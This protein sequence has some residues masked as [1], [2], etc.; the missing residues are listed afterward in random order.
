MKALNFQFIFMALVI[1]AGIFLS[2]H[3]NVHWFV[4]VPVVVLLF[5]GATGI[6]PGMWLWKKLGMK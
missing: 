4:Y 3:D 1:Y 6:C 5:A 2:G